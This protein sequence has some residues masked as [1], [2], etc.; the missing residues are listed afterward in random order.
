M[1]ETTLRALLEPVVADLGLDLEGVDVTAAGRRRR[2]C[3]VVDRDGGIDLDAVADVSKSV[4]DVLDASNVLGDA[5]YVLE[6]TSPGVDRPLTEPRHWRR[7]RQRLVACQ[8]TDGRT[9]EGRV[10]ESDDHTVTVD[11]TDGRVTFPMSEVS[12]ARV[13]IEFRRQEDE[14]E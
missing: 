10:I 11:T 6:V 13:Q 7:A 14:G 8:M 4:S 5:P 1:V 2:V 12:Q 3:I 9:I